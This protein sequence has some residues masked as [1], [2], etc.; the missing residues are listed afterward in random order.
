[1]PGPLEGRCHILEGPLGG[2]EW[3]WTTAVR[4]WSPGLFQLSQPRLRSADLALDTCM[5]MSPARS[6]DE[7]DCSVTKAGRAGAKC[8]A[9][10]E[11]TEAHTSGEVVFCWETGHSGLLA[12]CGCEEAGAETCIGLSWTLS[13]LRWEFL[14]PGP[15]ASKLACRLQLGEAWI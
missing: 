4:G 7:M 6:L 8:E 12:A 1:M 10:S 9:I 3:T 13:W 11:P 15:G 14:L 2:Q 5:S